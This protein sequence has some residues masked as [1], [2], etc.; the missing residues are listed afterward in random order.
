MG[1]LVLVRHGETQWN[2]EG[3]YQ[4][5]H[6]IPLSKTGQQ[7]AK[8]LAQFF[9]SWSLDAVYASDLTR[10]A[11]TASAIAQVHQLPVI[12]DPR[13]REYAFGVW[14]GLTRAEIKHKYP[15]L[16]YGRRTNIDIL[17]PGGE[18]G[19]QVQAR[20]FQ[21]LLEAADQEH[22]TVLAVSHGGTIRALLAKILEIDISKC[23]KLR[24]DNG[25]FS[26]ISWQVHDNRR[27]FNIH[28]IN[29][30]ADSK[31]Q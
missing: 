24:L 29:C 10:A 21:W 27:Q 16:Y 9:S 22:E 31:W 13:L 1:I 12:T 17:I 2:K 11:D 3:R 19:S 18:T 4:G 23:H 5:Q 25:G 20:A 7:Q 30:R 28:G 8:Q 6:D 15:E 14:E 26:I